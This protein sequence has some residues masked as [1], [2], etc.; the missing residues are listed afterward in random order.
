MRAIFVG[1][2]TIL[3]VATM[4]ASATVTKVKWDGGGIV[5]VRWKSDDDAKMTF[6]TAGNKIK[7]CLLYT[8][9]SPRD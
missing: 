3:L 6:Y 7:G 8:S 9:P 1:V 2:V 4:G 5:E